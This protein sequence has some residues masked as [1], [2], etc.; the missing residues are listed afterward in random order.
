MTLPYRRIV[1]ISFIAIFLIVTPIVI[2]YT[3]GYRYNFQTNKLQ[4][5]GILILKSSPL[6]AKIYLNG[7]LRKE[8]TPARITNLFPNDYTIK[9]EK[10]NFYP[11]QKNLP[12][13]SSLTTFAENI[14]LF[15][16]L[17]PAEVVE[18]NSELFSLAP[19]KEKIIYLDK[20]ETGDEVWLLNFK[21]NK[22]SLIYRISEGKNDIVN[23]EWSNDNQKVLLTV[24]F[25]DATDSHKYIM[26]NTETNEISVYQKLSD[27]YFTFSGVPINIADANLLPDLDVATGYSGAVAVLDKKTKNISVVKPTSLDVIFETKADQAAWSSDVKKL[28]YTTD[29]EIWIYNFSTEEKTLISRYSQEIKKV[30]WVNENYIAALLGGAVKIIEL[31]ERDQRNVIDLIAPGEINNFFI[32]SA[33]QSI[34]FSGVIGNKKGVFELPY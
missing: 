18:N 29:F 20:K 1:Y 17:L 12:I 19:N 28:L 24:N 21:N 34:Y 32:D 25:S 23:L 27:F 26:I 11:W 10:E 5:T 22:S 4:K 13:E 2:L 30:D 14:T 6:G 9:I 3:T 8:T 16:K 33:K 15:E 31:D 7:E